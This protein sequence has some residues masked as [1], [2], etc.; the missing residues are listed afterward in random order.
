[1]KVS[2]RS[3]GP[4][5]RREVL[6]DVFGVVQMTFDRVDVDDQQVEEVGHVLRPE[7]AVGEGEEADRDQV[8][9]VFATHS[10]A[11]LARPRSREPKG[12]AIIQLADDALDEPVAAV[13]RSVVVDGGLARQL[14]GHDA[15]AR[16]QRAVAATRPA[17][18]SEDASGSP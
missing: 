11:Q 14:V 18:T 5:L 12:V 7:R 16:R 1:M 10:V 9:P 15:A 13:P 8:P 6:Y 2:P 3:T 17:A 4:R